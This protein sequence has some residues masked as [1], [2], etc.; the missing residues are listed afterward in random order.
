MV[1][2]LFISASISSREPGISCPLR[3]E[4]SAVHSAFVVPSPLFRQRV[5]SGEEDIMPFDPSTDPR[6]IGL[7]RYA[8]RGG[9]RGP[10]FDKGVLSVINAILKDG[11]FVRSRMVS[12]MVLSR[13]Q[14]K[15]S[16]AIITQD[17]QAELHDYIAAQGWSLEQATEFLE[18]VDY[19]ERALGGYESRQDS[20]D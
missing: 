9:D 5:Q 4:G 17:E 3:Q 11:H 14:E 7:K 16:P 10:R 6:L 18:G 20:D 15:I 8:E 12:L 13:D 1:D 19:A 2:L